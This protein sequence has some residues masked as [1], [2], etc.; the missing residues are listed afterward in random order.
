MADAAKQE[1]PAERPSEGQ[2][3]WDG[4]KN[5]FTDAAVNTGAALGYGPAVGAKVMNDVRNSQNPGTGM[6]AILAQQEEFKTGAGRD[7]LN[8]IRNDK[9]FMS[10][11]DSA[12]RSDKSI[13]TRIA[14]AGENGAGIGPKELVA[15]LG[16]PQNRQLMTRVLNRVGEDANDG[17]GATYLSEVIGTAQAGDYKTLDGLLEQGGIPD[18]RVKMG[19]QMQD[20]PLGA[21]AGFL[22][23]PE[24][25]SSAI[26][27]WIDNPNGPLAGLSEGNK[28]MI[29]G[30]VE[31]LS[32]FLN[33]Y[34]PGQG[35]IDPYL[36]L[37]KRIGG[38]LSANGAEL[39]GV[40]QTPEPP[41]PDGD[42][43]G[44][45]GNPSAPSMRAAFNPLGLNKPAE[46]PDAGTPSPQVTRYENQVRGRTMAGGMEI[47]VG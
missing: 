47:G 45:Q 29:A 43:V 17:Y 4:V 28:N 24:K 35:I 38:E 10:A 8:A 7:Q 27:S 3:W 6:M 19:A 23:D 26:K 34:M 5:F 30:L 14:A 9:E 25:R 22:G 13:L 20:N 16:D 32:K 44:A 37:G 12:L 42:T 21:I 1:R 46:E 41:S 11:L 39:R 15:Q 40:A 18:D 33:I 2:G 31:A 36:D